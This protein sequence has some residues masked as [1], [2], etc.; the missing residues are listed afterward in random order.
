MRRYIYIYT[1][2]RVS[3]NAGKKIN[4]DA[5]AFSRSEQCGSI[6]YKG[7][8]LITKC[9]AR[10]KKET[11]EGRR[12]G[13]IT[14]K[15]GI[16]APLS[17]NKYILSTPGRETQL[18]SHHSCRQEG[19]GRQGGQ[20]GGR[21]RLYVHGGPRDLSL[22]AQSRTDVCTRVFRPRGTFTQSGSFF[23]YLSLFTRSSSVSSRLF[24]ILINDSQTDVWLV[25]GVIVHTHARARAREYASRLS[26]RAKQFRGIS[27]RSFAPFPLS[28]PR[29]IARVSLFGLRFFRS[30]RAPPSSAPFSRERPTLSLWRNILGR[31][32]SR[33]N[34]ES[35]RSR[36]VTIETP[37]MFLPVPWTRRKKVLLSRRGFE[38][39][40]R[41]TSRTLKSLRSSPR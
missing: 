35:L 34:A 18:S 13:S 23:L 40:L 20:R 41:V 4:H 11:G 37:G 17:G 5:N 15:R 10:E 32:F 33:R 14:D 38:I 31:H 9:F 29:H 6:H 7:A 36:G 27:P 2:S 16:H 22:S 12:G 3:A 28:L 1:L 25:I 39:A 24:L 30:S 8:Q 21:H 26:P 19:N